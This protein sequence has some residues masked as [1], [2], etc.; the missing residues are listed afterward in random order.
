MKL[1]NWLMNRGVLQPMMLE[2]E[3]AKKAHPVK[4]ARAPGKRP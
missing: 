4:A 3:S 2:R 1:E